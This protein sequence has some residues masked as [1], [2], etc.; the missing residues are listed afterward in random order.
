MSLPDSPWKSC[1]VDLAG[2]RNYWRPKPTT[3]ATDGACEF[4]Y[5]RKSHVGPLDTALDQADA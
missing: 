3:T 4:A 5:D 2:S 1:T